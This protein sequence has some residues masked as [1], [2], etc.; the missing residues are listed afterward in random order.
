MANTR[1]FSETIKENLAR[2]PEFRGAL[3]SEALACIAA[4]DLE[5]GKTVLREYVNATIGFLAL[6]EALGRSPKSIMRMLSP[7]GNP[8]ARNLSDIFAHLQTVENTKLTVQATKRK[9]A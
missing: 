1:S 2:D 3:L 8:L 9:A 7:Q 5:T 6:G 4:G